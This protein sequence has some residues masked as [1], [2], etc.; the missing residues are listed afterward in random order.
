M[1][2]G[3]IDPTSKLVVQTVLRH[4]PIARVGVA[5]RTGLSSGS[6]TRLTTPLIDAGILREQQPGPRRQ[7]G[8]PALPLAVVDDAARFVGVKVVPGYLHAVV[9]GLEGRVRATEAREADTTTAET[10]AMAIAAVVLDFVAEYD[11]TAVGVALAAAV[12]PM[13]Q[14]RAARLLGWDG[15]NLAARVT[16]LTGLPCTA[17]NDV[18]ALTLAEHWVGHG[19]GAQNFAVT[20]VGAG[21]GAGAVV[22]DELLVGHQGSMGMVGEAW[23][24]WGQRFH[25]ALADEPLLAAAKK[26]VGRTVTPEELR[27]AEKP[28]LRDLLTRAAQALGELVALAKQFWGPQ[29]VLLTGEGIIY[30]HDRLDVI[31]DT[32]NKHRFEDIDLPEVVVAELDFHAW[33]RGAAALATRLILSY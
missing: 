1:R 16:E 17:A 8:R 11:P 30:H 5:R 33:A 14:V 28:V 3:S 15:G 29:R 6:M 2:L 13:G 26:A 10:T 23:T 4:G 27:Q 12:D 19:R 22:G 7:L 31:Y 18:D 21:V 20:T 25:D 24:S 9:T 32:L